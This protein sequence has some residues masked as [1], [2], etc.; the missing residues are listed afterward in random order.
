MN[1]SVHI[2]LSVNYTNNRDHAAPGHVRCRVWSSSDWHV[3]ARL[4]YY[5]RRLHLTLSL[6]VAAGSSETMI[7]EPKEPLSELKWIYINQCTKV[8]LM[9]VNNRT[10]RH[11]TP[12]IH[13]HYKDIWF[14]LAVV[15]KFTLYCAEF[16][17][18]IA[19]CRSYSVG[20]CALAL[21][22]VLNIILF[23]LNFD[24]CVL[25]APWSVEISARSVPCGVLESICWFV[26]KGS[27]AARTAHIFRMSIN[28]DTYFQKSRF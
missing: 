6:V 20:R 16:G 27:N 21:N 3:I 5:R 17:L 19:S 1:T 2:N 4:L 22:R 10:S 18:N 13:T 24:W 23:S 11:S 12:L 14:L 9:N 7:S 15:K 8:D 28:F 25:F 26:P